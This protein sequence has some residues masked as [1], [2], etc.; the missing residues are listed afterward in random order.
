[1]SQFTRIWSPIDYEMDGK[2]EDC[3]RLPISIDTSAYGWIPIPLIC[4]KNGN[5]PTAVL[6]A[7]VHG[8]EYEGQIALMRLARNL[9]T[10]DVAGRIIIVPSLNFPSVEAGSRVSPIDDGNLNRL[11]PGLA[12]GTATSMIAHYV[13]S[14]LMPMAD[15]IVDLHSGG[16]SLLYMPCGLIRPGK[17]PEQHEKQIELLKVLGAPIGYLTDGTGMGGNTTL[18]AAAE[19]SGIPVI[20]A[21]LGGGAT[22]SPAGTDL[23]VNGAMRLLK[24][25][26]I[27]PSCKVE[28]AGPVRLMK[29]SSTGLMVYG[30]T[31]GLFEPLA[32]PGHD[33]AEGQLAGLIHSLHWPHREPQKVYFAR[34]GMVVSRRYPTLTKRGDC[35]FELLQDIASSP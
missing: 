16:R 20:T 34:S 1:M 29:S 2:Q 9:R 12:H 35:L 13:T 7:G 21:E 24:H 17:T 14:V 8:D 3:L 19:S 18:P 27:L 4:I 22:L 15:L 10:E 31:D 6:L 11:Y 32:E 28:T 33:V 30:E 26:G 5:G 23:A 25:V